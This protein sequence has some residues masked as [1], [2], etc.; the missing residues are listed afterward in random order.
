LE[1]NLNMAIPVILDVDTGVDDALAL[2]L[3]G[4][5]PELTILGVTCVAGN[6]SVDKVVTNSL[7][8]LDTVGR[9]D[10]PVAMG[11]DRP[12]VQAYR[13]AAHVHGEDGLGDL[14]WPRSD[15]RPIDAHAVDFI[16]DMV[17]TSPEPVTLICL[18]P[19]TNLAGFVRRYPQLLPQIRRIISMGGAMAT[20]GNIT[21]AAEFNIWSDPEAAAVV[22]ASG[23]PITMYGLDVFRTVKLTATD[24]TRLGSAGKPWS[25][26]LGGLLAFF[27]TRFDQ[28]NPGLGD[29]GAVA[30][31]I[32]PDALQTRPYRVEIE[33]TGAHTRGMTVVDRRIFAED[34]QTPAPPN[35]DVAHAIDGQACSRLFMDRL[36]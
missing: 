20:G 6:V 4:R 30:A 22:Y 31:A 32:L 23:V 33:L 12:L 27:Q 10:V 11:Y 9:S 1:K 13:P 36:L 28:P 19:L 15:R 25:A 29:A 26:L 35:A 14:G 34:A 3:A 24:V 21:P 2:M 5:S 8:V 16:A 7:T 18:A 17:S